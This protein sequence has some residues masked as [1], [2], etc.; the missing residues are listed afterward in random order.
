MILRLGS[1]PIEE[2]EKVVGKVVTKKKNKKIVAPG[3]L[4][5]HYAPRKPLII[6]ENESQIPRFKNKKIKIG[7]L[8]FHR[9]KNKNYF[10]DYK[11]LSLKG[12]LKEAASNFFDFLHQLD[13]GPAEIIYAEKIPEVGLGKAMMERLIKAAHQ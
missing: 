4:K 3:V 10:A 5:T 1:L 13:E 9:V 8:A 11:I 7:F 12:D 2:I 6:V